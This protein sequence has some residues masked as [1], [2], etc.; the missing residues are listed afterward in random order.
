[1][2]WIDRRD[3]L[4]TTGALGLSSL[5]P[6]RNASAASMFQDPLGIRDE[7]HVTR[8]QTYLNMSSVGPMPTVVHNAA[9]AYANDQQV[10]PAHRYSQSM[11]IKEQARL[12]FANLFGATRDEVAL[13]FS[14]SD[15]EN[16]VTN[17]LDLQPGDNVVI[18]ELHFITT[19]V[20]YRRLEKTKGI[21][22]RIVPHT[23]GRSR[24]EDFEART[25]ARTRLISVAW[26]SNRNGYRHRLSELADLAHRHGGLLFADGI[27]SLG[28][29]PTNLH[30]T[31]ADFVCANSYKYLLSGWGA[32]PFYVRE[33]HLTRIRPDRFGHNHVSKT[34]PDFHFELKQTAEQYEYAGLVYGTVTQLNAALGYISQV[35]LNRIETHTIA[36]AQN[37][38]D[39][40]AALGYK[41][42]TPADNPSCIMSFMHGR[43]TSH[44][45][46]VLNEEKISVTLRENG[47][48]LRASVGMFNNQDD[49]NH[50]LRVL[51]RLA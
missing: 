45:R 17:A 22:L 19:F 21:E 47:T 20:L 2:S 12:K 1:M 30:D 15:A 33:E 37:L 16:I 14:T 18:D 3:F 13:L 23:N 28:T 9:V 29:F 41:M 39:G 35:G 36:L 10:A 50:L 8:T 4:R 49:I 32:A 26:V 34:L 44:I 6:S 46:R 7:F 40:V 5:P 11:D 51:A 48:Q 27:Q 42:F 31:G 24:H 43:D 25:D 38:R